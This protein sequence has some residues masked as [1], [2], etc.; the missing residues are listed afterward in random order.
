MLLPNR[1]KFDCLDKL[2][3]AKEVARKFW[4][5]RFTAKQIATE[6]RVPCDQIFKRNQPERH[7]VEFDGGCA[8]HLGAVGAEDVDS[9]ASPREYAL[10]QTFRR[11]IVRMHMAEQQRL[12][13]RFRQARE[14]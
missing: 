1:L 10:Q 13:K 8:I 9:N 7:P 5:Q 11:W 14:V 6:P 4:R 12:S 3:H 2:Q